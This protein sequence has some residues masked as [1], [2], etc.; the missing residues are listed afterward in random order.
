MQNPLRQ[1]LWRAGHAHAAVLLVLSLVLLRYV[2]E[3]ALSPSLKQLVRLTTPAA[4]ILLPLAYFL[5]VAS[6]AA[7]E[8]NGFIYLA[9]AGAAVVAGGFLVLGIGLLRALAAAAELDRSSR[10]LRNERKHDGGL[11]N[12]LGIQREPKEVAGTALK[13][14][15][16]GRPP[17]EVVDAFAE[18]LHN[19]NLN[20]SEIVLVRSAGT[21]KEDRLMNWVRGKKGLSMA[22]CLSLALPACMA[23]TARFVQSDTSFRARPAT[24]PPKVFMDAAP[25]VPFASV[26]IVEVQGPVTSTREA[27][28]D[29]AVSEGTKLGCDILV[30]EALYEMR[31]GARHRY[32]SGVASWLFTCGVFDAAKQTEETAILADAT[33]QEIVQ[34]EYGDPICVK[35]APTGSHITRNICRLPGAYLIWGNGTPW[36]ANVR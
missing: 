11:G 26:G 23:K 13:E 18:G 5:S 33:A 29:A 2:D 32:L 19:G 10:H 4:A 24:A 22:L 9:Y 17:L 7:T 14:V 36:A 8:P 20:K 15:R 28:M 12:P 31:R 35:Q 25:E 21:L 27:L 6:P 34:S 30:H 3:A 1:N 16:S